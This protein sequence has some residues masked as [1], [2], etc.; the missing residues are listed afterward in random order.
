MT[1]YITV[2]DKTTGKDTKEGCTRQSSLLIEGKKITVVGI[3]PHMTEITFDKE[4]AKKLIKVL[5]KLI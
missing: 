2:I 5:E 1:E 3:M 4:N